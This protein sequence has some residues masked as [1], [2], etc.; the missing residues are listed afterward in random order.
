V[1]RAGDGPVTPSVQVWVFDVDGCLVDS[2]TGTSLRPGARAALAHLRAGGHSLLL[3]SA[4]GAAYARQRAIDHEIEH[5]FDAFH[6]KEGRD[7][8]GYYLVAHLHPDVRRL[9]FVD[10]RTEE[11]H[12]ALGRFTVAPYIVHDPGDRDFHR[13]MDRLSVPGY[14]PP[15]I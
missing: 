7:E 5:F 8:S 14:R 9:V 2:M 6:A 15:Q 3:W 13:L 12:P 1:N 4:G 11:I 10:D